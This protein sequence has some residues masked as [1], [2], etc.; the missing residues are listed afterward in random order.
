MSEILLKQC[1]FCEEWF[2]A[3]KIQEPMLCRHPSSPYS[4][5]FACENCL[6]TSRMERLTAKAAKALE[7]GAFNEVEVTDGGL[8]VHLVR[9]TPMP[10]YAPVTAAGFHVPGQGY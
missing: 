8:K 6:K 2:P 9:Y 5:E 1:F 7:Y 4:H 10:Y 3:D